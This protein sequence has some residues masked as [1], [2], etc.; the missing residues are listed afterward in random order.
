MLLE[1]PEVIRGKAI[2][3]SSHDIRNQK[4]HAAVDRR[5]SLL[6]VKAMR[7]QVKRNFRLEDRHR[8]IKDDTGQKTPVLGL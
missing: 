5:A 1:Y 7:D 4:E 3:S 6:G 8:V 2:S